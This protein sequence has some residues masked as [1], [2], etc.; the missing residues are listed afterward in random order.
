MVKHQKDQVAA[1][2][3]LVGLFLGLGIGGGIYNNWTAG[4]LIGLA[5]GFLA[6]AIAK[7]VRKK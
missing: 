1:W 2:L 5:V 4:A 3:F 7:I 6:G